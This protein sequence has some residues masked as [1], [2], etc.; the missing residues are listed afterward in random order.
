[1]IRCHN[2]SSSHLRTFPQVERSPAHHSR[3]FLHSLITPIEARRTRSPLPPEHLFS[4]LPSPL[5]SNTSLTRLAI[6]TSSP[7]PN[8]PLQGLN[9][10]H[11][12]GSSLHSLFSAPRTSRGQYKHD[13]GTNTVV[14]PGNSRLSRRSSTSRRTCSCAFDQYRR[15]SRLATSGRRSGRCE[16]PGNHTD[17]LSTRCTPFKLGSASSICGANILCHSSHWLEWWKPSPT[18]V[19]CVTSRN[20]LSG[21]SFANHPSAASSKN[22]KVVVRH[23]GATD[24]AYICLHTG[25]GMEFSGSG[26]SSQFLGPSHASCSPARLIVRHLPSSLHKRLY[27]SSAVYTPGFSALAPRKLRLYISCSERY[28]WHG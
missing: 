26:V 3:P 16:R 27:S 9:N 28:S 10:H 4:P 18:S 8:C 19:I 1:M 21:T 13:C 12:C 7:A 11:E 2:H 25:G 5:P 6:P 15:I 14:R 22:A 24:S 23:A 20:L 17:S